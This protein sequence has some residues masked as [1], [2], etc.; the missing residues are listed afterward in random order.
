MSRVRI[1][2]CDLCG[3]EVRWNDWYDAPGPV[4]VYVPGGSTQFKLEIEEV[5]DPCGK[6]ISRLVGNLHKELSHTYN[7]R[8]ATADRRQ[9]HEFRPPSSERRK[10]QRRVAKYA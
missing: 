2:D 8:K 1:F 4:K 6:R 7:H 10:V 5:C 3:R 9:I